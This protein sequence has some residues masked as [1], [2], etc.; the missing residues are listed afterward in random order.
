MSESN[1]SSSNPER[2]LN[3][4][5]L[6]GLVGRVMDRK[7][8]D[9]LAELV[10]KHFGNTVPQAGD[11]KLDVIVKK[12]QDIVQAEGRNRSLVDDVSQFVINLVTQH[13][14]SPEFRRQ[15]SAETRLPKIN[16]TRHVLSSDIREKL[17]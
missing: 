12:V 15:A 16:R 7:D 11:P 5:V 9:L 17:G 8:G 14:N 2:P 10:Y 3:T 13:V 6:L 1:L 4:G